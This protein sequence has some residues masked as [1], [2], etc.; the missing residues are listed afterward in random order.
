MTTESITTDPEVL[1]LAEAVKAGDTHGDES[2]AARLA[3][4]LRD[5]CDD[6][7]E[8]AADLWIQLGLTMD[9][10]LD[11]APADEPVLRDNGEPFP[12]PDLV[13]DL[14]AGPL[15]PDFGP[16]HLARGGRVECFNE[17]FSLEYRP[18]GA[19]H[20]QLTRSPIH[21]WESN[22]P[23]TRVEVGQVVGLRAPDG[24]V[25]LFEVKDDPFAWGPHFAEII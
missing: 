3:D 19:R 14:V 5:A 18:N 24:T 10:L 11:T 9:Q 16:C 8:A 1:A 17:T 15:G 20:P 13:L 2:A 6:N 12:E 23:V 7:D 4:L 22:V 25:E 21:A